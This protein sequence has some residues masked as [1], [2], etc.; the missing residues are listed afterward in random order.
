MRFA[1]AEKR[2]ELCD[3]AGC[4]ILDMAVGWLLSRPN[5]AS[6]IAGATKPEQ[7]EA[8]TKAGA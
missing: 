3:A 7:V 2:R 4:S 1:Q 5:V 8:N 6:V